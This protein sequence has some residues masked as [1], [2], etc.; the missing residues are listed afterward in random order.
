MYHLGLEIYRLFE[1]SNRP[2]LK[3]TCFSPA[4]VCRCRGLGLELTAGFESKGFTFPFG[5]PEPFS[6]TSKIEQLPS[7]FFKTKWPCLKAVVREE[8]LRCSP[9][10]SLRTNR[11]SRKYC[12]LVDY[13]KHKLR[14]ASTGCT[15]Q[16]PPSS[17]EDDSRQSSTWP[18]HRRQRNY[19]TR[20]IYQPLKGQI[21]T[22]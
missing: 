12:H 3:A 2:E 5:N 13:K 8:D 18:E 7:S 19:V 6:F 22:P 14:E 10:G 1:S 16:T 21:L 20:P 15:A 17:T 9:Q 11:Q 4:S